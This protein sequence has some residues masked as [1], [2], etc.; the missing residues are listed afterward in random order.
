MLSPVLVANNLGNRGQRVT[1]REVAWQTKRRA[2][3]AD[4][5][6]WHKHFEV[7]RRVRQTNKNKIGLGHDTPPLRNSLGPQSYTE[8]IYSCD[9][10]HV[11][12]VTLRNERTA[13]QA[14]SGSDGV[15]RP[16]NTEYYFQP[17]VFYATGSLALI[18][19]PNRANHY[20]A[21]TVLKRSRHSLGDTGRDG[22]AASTGTAVVAICL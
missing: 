1:A 12:H 2:A 3:A 18:Y 17:I 15:I 10:H 14:F 5:S 11:Y 13:V 7:M 21:L 19:C 20:S 22:E 9:S 4:R 16:N 8:V 6:L